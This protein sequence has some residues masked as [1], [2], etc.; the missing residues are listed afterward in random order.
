MTSHGTLRTFFAKPLV[1]GIAGGLVVAVLGVLA[2]RAGWLDVDDDPALASQAPLGSATVDGRNSDSAPDTNPVSEGALT[3]GAIYE[4]SGN[5]VAYIEAAQGGQGNAT[6]PFGSDQGGTATGSGFLM[7][8]EG[9]VLT[10]A[11]VV[12]GSDEVTVQLGEDG[13]ELEAE[14]LGADSSTDVAVLGVDPAAVDV[15]PLQ[16]GD[17]SAL[18]VGDSVVAIGNPFGLD[19]TVTSGIVSALQRQIN[20]PDGF[21]IS[22]VIQTDAAIN[23][24]N[25][26]GPLFGAN[27]EVIGINSQIATDGGNGFDGVGFAVPIDTVKTVAGQL[28]EDG[29]ADH[30]FIGISGADL[31][32]EIA[33]ALNIDAET[34]ALV[35]EVT[36][37]GPAEKAGLEAG[38]TV[39]GIEGAEVAADGDLIVAAD[40]E[41]VTGMED[42]IAVIN[43]KQ[44]GDEVELEVWRDGET[45]SVTV[46]LG[47]RPAEEPGQAG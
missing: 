35:Q 10:N 1:A 7:D 43:A 2:I 21:T 23:P 44:P 36:P 41:E 3:P 28:L 19:R 15:E 45:R 9:H 22:D 32:P 40:G 33:D 11:H 13:E 20:A 34:G 17:S 25:S 16:L 4:R 46:E 31:T 26:G 5:S 42:L 14:V 8:D 30:A 47:D 27:G 6:S 29:T 18:T 24:G 38:E 39:V 37:N 12:E